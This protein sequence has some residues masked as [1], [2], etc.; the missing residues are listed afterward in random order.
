[1]KKK[2]KLKKSEKGTTKTIRKGHQPKQRAIRLGFQERRA[3]V[4][5]REVF[6]KFKAGVKK[7]EPKIFDYC[8][9]KAIRRKQH[10]QQG[11]KK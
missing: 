5:A 11:K 10:Q 6:E 3:A 7:F 2:V 8:E 1:M 4:R 9:T